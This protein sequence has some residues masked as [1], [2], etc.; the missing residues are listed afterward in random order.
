MKNLIIKRSIMSIVELK[1]LDIEKNK[2]GLIDAMYVVDLK[3]YFGVE[4]NNGN[5]LLIYIY[6]S[7]KTCWAEEIIILN[8]R[9]VKLINPNNK[10]GKIMFYSK[11]LKNHTD[12]HDTIIMQKGLIIGKN[13]GYKDKIYTLDCIS[14]K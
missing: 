6:N 14:K 10:K 4:D 11:N 13:W 12:T 1:V 7:M 2:M 5:K 9:F 3:H 8:S